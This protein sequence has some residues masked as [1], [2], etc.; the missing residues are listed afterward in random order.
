MLDSLIKTPFSTI[1]D[2]FFARVTSDMYI[3]WTE[4]DTYN[5]LQDLLINGLPLF[6]FPRFNLFDYEEGYV[7]DLGIYNGAESD[8][9]PV[10]AHGWVG[11]AFNTVLTD[12][13]INIISLA[14]VVEWLGQQLHTTELTKE[15]MTGVDFKMSSQANHMAKLNSLVKEKRTECFHLQRLY[16]RRKLQDGKIKST[17][18]K[19]MSTPQYGYKIQ[20]V[21]V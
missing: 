5:A 21:E 2:R 9:K 7:D 20:D 17:L 16:K 13:E 6:E 10:H 3:S 4:M 14:M 12:E 18:G 15:K 19:I 11:G 8:Y 1:Y